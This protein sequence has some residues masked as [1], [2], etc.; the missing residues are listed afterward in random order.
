MGFIVNEFRG[1]KK[2]QKQKG[3]TLVELLIIIAII[4]I[5]SVIVIF[6]LNPAELL[7]QSRDVNRIADLQTIKS[8]LGL[9]VIQGG[10][11][12]GVASTSYLSLSD[13]AATSS[14][15]NQCQS[16][17]S[18]T[19][20]AGWVNHCAS[21][22]YFRNADATGWIPVNFSSTAIGSS[23]S[24]LPVDPLNAS[25]SGK[26]YVY[27]TSGLNR[28]ELTASLE[29]QKYQS[30]ATNDGGIYNDLYETG[31]D[32]TLANVDYANSFSGI[33]NHN[34]YGYRRSVTVG[35]GVAGTLTNFPMLISGTYAY[36][37]A[38]STGGMVQNANG[39]DIVFTSDSGCANKLNFEQESYVTTTGNVVYWVQVPSITN[40]TVIYLCYDNA[41]VTTS[42]QNIAGTWDS[43][44]VAVYH[45]A[46]G[47]SL[48][49]NDST[50]NA[51]NGTA[52]SIATTTGEIGGGMSDAAA[53]G[54]NTGITTA[55][56]DFMTC[57]WFNS[58]NSNS[59]NQRLLDKSYN[60]GFWMGENN[61]ATTWGGGVL[62]TSPPYATFSTLSSMTSWH[63][64]CHERSG[65]LQT[66][67]VDGTTVTTSTVS[68]SATDGSTLYIGSTFSFSAAFSG[69][70]DEV[71]ISNIARSAGWI[72]TSYNNQ[73]SPSSF[74]TLGQAS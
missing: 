24:Q 73:S 71:E 37:S 70:E 21:P 56:G 6:V 35:S 58:N 23:I 63:Y 38:S 9:Y 57:L 5:L 19:I 64:L 72:S 65:T 68:G 51:H 3:F 18:S 32:L 10:A 74:Y 43:N 34:G 49:V 8:A 40:G 61:S 69:S 1:S 45:F 53:G 11:V 25:S 28:F 4:A 54:I 14:A 22:I 44:Y 16:M 13:S 60:T 39:Y 2:G 36:L 33:N 67:T 52:T 7:R 17:G 46:S 31:N 41:S 27:Q 15:G 42:Q 20:P 48:N 29:S 55:F 30:V 62:Q 50:S 26:Y 12:V 59:T 66:V 47:G